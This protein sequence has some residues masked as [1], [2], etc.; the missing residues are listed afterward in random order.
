M[1]DTLLDVKSAFHNGPLK[2]EVYVTQPSGF[3]IKGLGIIEYV[4]F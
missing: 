1:E 2:E 3:E 4:A